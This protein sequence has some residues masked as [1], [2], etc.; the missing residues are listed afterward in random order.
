M[1]KVILFLFCLFTHSAACHAPCCLPL[2][3]SQYSENLGSQSDH[4]NAGLTDAVVGGR[5]RGKRGSE[6]ILGLPGWWYPGEVASCNLKADNRGRASR[7][8]RRAR[9]IARG[10][11]RSMTHKENSRG[12]VLL[13]HG[14]V[15]VGEEEDTGTASRVQTQ[16]A[17][18]PC[19]GTEILRCRVGVRV[20]G[21]QSGQGLSE[22]AGWALRPGAA[23]LQTGGAESLTL[24]RG[25]RGWGWDTEEVKFP[26]PKPPIREARQGWPLFLAWATGCRLKCE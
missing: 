17:C 12:S 15:C 5:T 26:R 4:A 23:A 3:R 16:K 13:I 18:R 8:V 1:F 9:V 10:L 21:F 20:T 14:G 2:Q 7:A 11:G 22:A 6:G 25:S 24:G 19:L